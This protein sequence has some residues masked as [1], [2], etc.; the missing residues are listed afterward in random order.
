MGHRMPLGLENLGR[1]DERTGKLGK[2]ELLL[3][4][5]RETHFVVV[6]VVAVVV[7]VCRWIFLVFAF[8]NATGPKRSGVVRF[9]RIPLAVNFFFLLYFFFYY[10]FKL[11]F[12][13]RPRPMGF[14]GL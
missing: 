3:R 11:F 10:L 5:F 4:L 8:W 7:V 14:T 2:N 12:P 9:G 13:C 6:V 1:F